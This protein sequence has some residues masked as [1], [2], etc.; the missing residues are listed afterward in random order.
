MNTLIPF[1]SPELQ[2]FRSAWV[3]YPTEG[4]YSLRDIIHSAMDAVLS[5]ELPPPLEIQSCVPQL[6]MGQ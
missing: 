3:F 1:Q 5:R 4:K 6:S 2:T